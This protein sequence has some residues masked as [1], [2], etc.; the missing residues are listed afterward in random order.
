M[1]LLA[2]FGALSLEQRRVEVLAPACGCCEHIAVCR[3]AIATLLPNSLLYELLPASPS[4][5]RY[6][7]QKKFF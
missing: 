2:F 6:E 1:K 7:E 3:A 5:G 4:L